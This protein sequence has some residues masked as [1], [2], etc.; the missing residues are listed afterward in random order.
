MALDA[1]FALEENL[2][3]KKLGFLIYFDWE[4]FNK[5]S[6]KLSS[7]SEHVLSFWP[8]LFPQGNP[9]CLADWILKH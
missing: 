2:I 3:E 6:K 4:Y 9:A 5:L 7:T 8:L 1:F